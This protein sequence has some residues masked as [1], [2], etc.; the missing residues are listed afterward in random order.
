MMSLYPFAVAFIITGISGWYLIPW[1]HK[2]KFGQEIREEGPNWHQKK[3]GTP[4]MGGIMFIIG[5]AVAVGL[6]NFS[7]QPRMLLMFGVSLGFGFVGFIDD[8]IKVVKKRNLGLT[9]SQKFGLQLVIAGMYLIALYFMN[10][11]DTEIIIPFSSFKYTAPFWLYIPLVM[12]VATGTVN[13]VNLTDG[14]DGL[15]SSITIV[16][17]LFFAVAAGIMLHTE[18][19]IFS[20]CVVG[21]CLGFLLYNRHPAKVFMGDTGS[22]FLGGAVCALAI[23][24]K[25]PLILVIAGFVYLFEALSVIMQVTYFKLTGKR[26]FKMSPVHHHFEMCGWNEKKIVRV[27]TFITLI[28]CVLAIFAILPSSIFLTEL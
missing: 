21:G 6:M 27:F 22:L 19:M 16:V 1:L 26:I 24:M 7:V 2:L 4:T 10:S 20:V 14:L 23:G 3:S 17:C 25:M 28:L 5:I 18:E 11:L 13:A 9:S 8:Y 15:A 12:L